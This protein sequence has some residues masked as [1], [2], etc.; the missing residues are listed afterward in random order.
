MGGA[1]WPS[2]PTRLRAGLTLGARAS[3]LAPLED[4]IGHLQGLKR[5][6][7]A[8]GI[9]VELF[10]ALTVVLL[11]LIEPAIRPIPIA[12]EF[13]RCGHFLGIKIQSVDHH[14][15]SLITGGGRVVDAG[16]QPQFTAQLVSPNR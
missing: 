15:E 2:P 5:H 13:P 7:T 8:A 9:R 11:Q 10:A 12:D 16:V 3:Q 1:C 14:G 4:S 6:L